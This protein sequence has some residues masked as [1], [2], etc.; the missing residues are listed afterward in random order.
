MEEKQAAASASPRVL[1]QPYPRL[2]SWEQY[3]EN[4]VSPS[5]VRSSL[6]PPSL[7]SSI[8]LSLS[9]ASSSF[10]SSKRT[11]KLGLLLLPLFRPT[12]DLRSPERT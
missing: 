11:T 8:H 9:N 12:S 4:V 3:K 10:S 5:P 1:M 2:V 7:P 6:P